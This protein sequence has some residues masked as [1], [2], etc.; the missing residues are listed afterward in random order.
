[1]SIARLAWID[2][3]DR[4]PADISALAEIAAEIDRFYGATEVEPPEI[5]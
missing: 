3:V 4:E 5:L 1:M 2:W